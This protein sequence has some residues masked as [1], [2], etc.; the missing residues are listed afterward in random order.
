M[1]AAWL[2]APWAVW[3]RRLTEQRVPHAVLIA[4]SEGLGKRALATDMVGSLLCTA[5]QADR[6]ACGACRGCRLLSAGT[7]PDFY[8]IGLEPNDK[9]DVRS[10]IVVDQIRA[11]RA[12]LAQ[13]SQFGGWRVALLDP[14]DAMNSASFNALLKTLEEPE[15]QAL[16]VLISDRP[17]RLPATIRSR[18]QR[19]DLR[20][21]ARAQAL[22][23]LEAQG[24]RG[25]AA[26][27]ALDLA[28]GNPG[29]ARDYGNDAVRARLLAC[30]RDLQS[31]AAGRSR[32][33]DAVAAW[34]KDEP[35]QRLL[36]AAQALRVC[37]WASRGQGHVGKALAELANLT[38]TADFPKLA[39]WWD[40]ANRV[41]EQLKTPLRGDLLLLELLREF[42][43]LYASPRQA[44]G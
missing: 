29:L 17:S 15:A 14:A 37:A 22:S 18:C 39:A 33:M 35:E 26:E 19:I 36:L 20:F 30:V 31:L 41:R 8:R 1:T 44:R 42:A 16:L 23:W 27:E 6:R 4:G 3:Q 34:L 24:V 21:P 7:H 5:P 28:A 13:T 11:L 38:A 32:A 40:R 25:E 43:A 2:E 9:G 12:S 10:E